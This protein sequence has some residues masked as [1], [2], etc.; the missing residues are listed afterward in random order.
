M[1]IDS[2]T[3]EPARAWQI[4]QLKILKQNTPGDTVGNKMTYHDDQVA[5][6]SIISLH[7]NKS[8]H[9]SRFKIDFHSAR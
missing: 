2:V 4:G 7:P 9:L 1:E 5:W 8:Q 6:S 3:S